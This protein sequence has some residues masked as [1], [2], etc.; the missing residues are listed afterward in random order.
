MESKFRI[1]TDQS[2]A[3]GCFILQRTRFSEFED[4]RSNQNPHAQHNTVLIQYSTDFSF[5]ALNC[6]YKTPNNDPRINPD[7][8]DF[9][10]G[11]YDYLSEIAGDILPEARY[12][13]LA[14]Y[15]GQQQPRRIPPS[16]T[17]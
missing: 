3:P 14:E 11:A 8:T 6:G 7:A 15:F 2:Y 17:N 16:M 4:H 10:P 1:I 12:P 5:L 9:I 13:N